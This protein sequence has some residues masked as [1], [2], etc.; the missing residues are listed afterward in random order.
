MPSTWS[1]GVNEPVSRA[2]S[3]TDAAIPPPELKPPTD[4]GVPS[5]ASAAATSWAW[6]WATG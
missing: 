4:T 6:C 5:A 3:A 1:V 2:C